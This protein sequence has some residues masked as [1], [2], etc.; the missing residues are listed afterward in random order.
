MGAWEELA[1]ADY[2]RDYPKS[3]FDNLE[4]KKES[5]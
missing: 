2:E 4:Q 1:K 5:M 3:E